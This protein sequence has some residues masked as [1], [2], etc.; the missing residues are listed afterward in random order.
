MNQCRICEYIIYLRSFSAVCSVFLKD[1]PIE[2]SH[3]G[4]TYILPLGKTADIIILGVI[5]SQA[6]R[7][8]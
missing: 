1:L 6:R 4:H 7:E 5:Y 3:Q 2:N 8:Q